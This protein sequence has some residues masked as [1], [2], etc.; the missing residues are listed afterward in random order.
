M[1]ELPPFTIELAAGTPR[2]VDDP[3]P[4][5]HRWTM[6]HIPVL[7]ISEHGASEAGQIEQCEICDTAE[8]ELEDE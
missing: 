8:D 4:T 7:I 1:A 5:C 2:K 3:C 6:W